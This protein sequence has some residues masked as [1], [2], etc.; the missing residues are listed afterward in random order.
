[1]SSTETK[2]RTDLWRHQTFCPF[3]EYDSLETC[4]RI[5]HLVSVLGL[6]DANS[7]KW[8]FHNSSDVVAKVH[9]CDDYLGSERI[10][11]DQCCSC[12]LDLYFFR[13]GE[14]WRRIVLVGRV[15]ATRPMAIRIRVVCAQISPWQPEPA[16]LLYIHTVN[17]SSEFDVRRALHH[18]S[19]K[20]T[21]DRN[22]SN[23]GT[24]G[25]EVNHLMSSIYI[26]NNL[27]III[28]HQN[29]Q[30]YRDLVLFTFLVRIPKDLIIRLYILSI[31]CHGPS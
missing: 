25:I 26:I 23:S 3:H 30:S 13:H 4:P 29:S 19:W 14:N 24:A 18:G 8:H 20:T 16:T 28:I 17:I 27:I 11:A 1:M 10:I 9:V 21:T 22:Q 2:W 31:W 7:N 15:E 5:L 6:E 12:F